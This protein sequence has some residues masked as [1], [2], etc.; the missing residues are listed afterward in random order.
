MGDRWQKRL[1]HGPFK[2]RKWRGTA[3]LLLIAGFCHTAIFINYWR[4]VNYTNI[5]AF[6]TYKM[7]ISHQV[8]SHDDVNITPPTLHLQRFSELQQ[9]EAIAQ[10][11]PQLGPCYKGKLLFPDERNNICQEQQTSKWTLCGM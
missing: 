2:D 7:D 6:I 11:D 5:P 4:N 10:K 1:G 3:I 9:I 8:S